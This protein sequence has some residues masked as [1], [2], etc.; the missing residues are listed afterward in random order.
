MEPG[1]LLKS[2]YKILEQLGK[3]G[4]GEVYLATDETLDTK[5][6]VK[7][8]HNLSTHTSAQFIREARLLASLKH[9]NLPRVIDYFTENDS[10]YLVMDFIPG[11][12]LKKIVEGKNEISFPLVL[13]WAIQLGNA[14]SYLHTQNPPIYHR[15]IKPANIK[16]TPAGEVVLVDFGIAKTGEA[17]Q[18]TQTGAWAFSPG[19]APPEQ[20]SGM[21]TGPYT[22]QFSLA[23]TLY[24][25][26]VGK[27]PADSARRLMGEE[28]YVPLINLIPSIP[29][30]FSTAMDKALSIKPEARFSS[31]ADFIGALSNATPIP[32]PASAQKTVVAASRGI[33]PMVTP[34][35]YPPV[36]ATPVPQA[37]K[38][39]GS[40]VWLVF[41]I[42]AILG[43]LTGG[44]F[45]LK[46]NGMIGGA[47]QNAPVPTKTQQAVIVPTST[48][49]AEIVPTNT[50]EQPTPTETVTPTLEA[51]VFTKIGHGGKVAFI[52][53]FQGDGYQQIWLMDVGMDGNNNLVAKNLTQLTFSPDD[54][55]YP[56][57]SPDGTKLIYSGWSNDTSFNG[58]PYAND[59]WMLDVTDPSKQP[60]DLSQMPANDFFA[61]WSPNGKYIAFTNYLRDKNVPQLWI[62]NSDGSKPTLL[63]ILGFSDLYST[64]SANGDWLY[65][66]NQTG[67][68]S[69]V[70]KIFQSNFLKKSTDRTVN[71]YLKFDPLTDAG[72][73]GNVIEPNMS[74]DGSL[75]AY[76]NFFGTKRNI[77]TAVTTDHGNTVTKLTDTGMDY[78]PCWSPDGKWIIFTSERD[79][80]TE[81]YIMDPSGGKITNLTNRASMDKEPSWQPVAIQ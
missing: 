63:S 80:N 50:V 79:G 48:S 49:T 65:Y 38:K 24:Y 25:L 12:D 57:W 33:P 74:R 4:M 71:D 39:S 43:V 78:A 23:A 68:L 13:K 22:D 10:Q 56:S 61:A 45:V 42:I 41:A 46:A 6:A 54:K 81:I 30:Y 55:S 37:S 9:P 32:D 14:L 20:V 58:T 47:T 67:Q 60:V 7:A 77:Y 34:Q 36:A 73:L 40:K 11:D 70:Q 18:E 76:T 75:L 27:P 17:S 53:D 1:M 3:G 16:L 31:V 2:R 29:P 8:N 5:V 52:S 15:D 26:L 69:V 19:F 66:I 51:P 21:R 28:E 72:R 44:Y 64:W 59:I 62:M 35:T